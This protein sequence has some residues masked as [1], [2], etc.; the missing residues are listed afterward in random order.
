[1]SSS[2]RH[3][4]LRGYEFWK[5]N[6]FWNA[7]KNLSPAGKQYYETWLSDLKQGDKQ[8]KPNNL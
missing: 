1:M 5:K 6:R 4:Y 3:P 8:A 7:I 2:K